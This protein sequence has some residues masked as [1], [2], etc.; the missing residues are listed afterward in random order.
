LH[1]ALFSQRS[2]A[3]DSKIDGLVCAE[4]C[5]VQLSLEFTEQSE[6][7]VVAG[8]AGR[9]D[10]DEETRVSRRKVSRSS[11]DVGSRSSSKQMVS[12]GSGIVQKSVCSVGK[13]ITGRARWDVGS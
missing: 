3:K 7:A 1:D 5:D 6:D 10:G 8:M 4:R 11:S 9:G 2:R 12:K 13:E